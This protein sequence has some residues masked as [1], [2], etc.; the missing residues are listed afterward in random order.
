M[1]SP[2][3][4][5]CTSHIN[6]PWFRLGL[7]H[8]RPPSPEPWPPSHL[9]SFH[10]L[11]Q[12]S[13]LAGGVG[14]CL[15]FREGVNRVNDESPR[16]WGRP[17]Q[18]WV[19]EVRGRC[20]GSSARGG[21]RETCQADREA[22]PSGGRSAAAAAAAVMRRRCCAGR[23]SQILG[24]GARAATSAPAAAPAPAPGP[25]AALSDP[26]RP[27]PPPRALNGCQGGPQRGGHHRGP[28]PAD[29]RLLWLLPGLL[30]SEK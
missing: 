12:A 11:D 9:L 23:R 1:S 25:R 8:P 2:R 27:G 30:Q 7:S 5:A 22:G 28:D 24:A 26:P 10:A 16:R 20:S 19:S 6:S 14:E 15:V 4:T 17:G 29:H 3:A 21:G 18:R 13:L